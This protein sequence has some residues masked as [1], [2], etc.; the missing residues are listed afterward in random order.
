MSALSTADQDLSRTK[1][2]VYDPGK[3]CRVF[4]ATCRKCG[5]K[6]GVFTPPWREQGAQ[7]EK[8]ATMVAMGWHLDFRARVARCPECASA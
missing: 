7:A 1:R 5:A 4:G 6:G 8:V 2:A 3:R